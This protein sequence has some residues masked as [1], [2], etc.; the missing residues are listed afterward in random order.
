[1]TIGKRRTKTILAIGG[2]VIALFIV[3]LITTMT[4]GSG[5]SALDALLKS[6]ANGRI[7]DVDGSIGVETV[8]DIHYV[9][10]GNDLTIYFGNITMDFK[11]KELQNQGILTKLEMI[12]LSLD[13][14]TLKYYGE[15][16]QY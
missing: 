8:D 12:G 9:W 4:G 7:V 15:V 13:G 14:K 5:V 11:E 3:G 16:V 2:L 1:M 10:E 6:T